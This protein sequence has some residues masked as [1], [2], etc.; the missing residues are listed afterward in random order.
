MAD[1]CREIE[2]LLAEYALNS[3]EDDERAQVESHLPSCPNCSALLSEYRAV[4]E[5]LLMA[6][7]DAAPPDGLRQA[8]MLR[9]ETTAN[10]ASAARQPFGRRFS[11]W[12]LALGTAVAAVLLVNLALLQQVLGLRQDQARLQSRAGCE[13][14]RPG[15]RCLSWCYIGAVRGPGRL[16]NYCV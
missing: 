1:D 10:A 9:M 2:P 8:L 5:G 16:W 14:D 12:R 3:L 13:S 15:H 6:L 4:A 7:P 11:L